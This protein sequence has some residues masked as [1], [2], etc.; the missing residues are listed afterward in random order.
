MMITFFQCCSTILFFIASTSCIT[1]AQRIVNGTVKDEMGETLP[2]VSVLVKGT[3]FFTRTDTTGKFIIEVPKDEKVL[4]FSFLGFQNQEITLGPSNVIEI[5]LTINIDLDEIVITALNIPRS[6]RSLPY[7]VQTV[8]GTTLN[9]MGSS[10]SLEGKIAGLQVLGLSEM[11]LNQSVVSVFRGVGSLT[12]AKT[13]LVVVEGTPVTRDALLNINP[14]NVESITALKGPSAAALYGQRGDAGVLLIKLKKAAPSDGIGIEFNQSMLFDKVTLLPKYQ[15]RYAGGGSAELIRFNWQAGMPEGWKALEGKYYHDY[16]DD[17]SWGPPMDGQEYI[18]WYAW[19][20][21]TKYSFKT[22]TLLPQPNNVRDF[23]GTGLRTNTSLNF[24]KATDAYSTRFSFAFRDEKGLIPTTSNRKFILSST[25]TLNLNKHLILGVNINYSPTTTRGQIYDGT[26]NQ[27]TGSFNSWFHRNLNIRALRELKDLRSPE[28]ILASWNHFN[29]GSYLS[30]P[31]SFYRGNWWFNFYS[32]FDNIEAVDEQKS[33]FGDVNLTYK[34]NNKVKIAGF[35]RQNQ[36]SSDYES[37][38]YNILEQSITSRNLFNSYY[39]YNSLSIE[40]N[41]E[42]LATWADNFGPFNFEANLGGN[43]RQENFKTISNG[44]NQGLKV[45]DLF[46]LNN[47]VVLTPPF[48]YRSKKEVRS[49][50]AR[51]SFAWKEMAYLDWSLRNDWSS[52]LPKDNNAYMYPSVGLSFIFSE[53]F[54]PNNFL[55]FGKLRAG[56]AQVGFD[57]GPYSLNPAYGFLNQWGSNLVITAPN[58]LVEP[59]IKPS[60]SSSYET[61]IDLKMLKNR[62]GISATFYTERRIN[63]ILTVSTSGASGIT[64][65]L[66]NAGRLDR[67]GLEFQLNLM[68]IKRKNFTWDAS[69]NFARMRNKVVELTEGLDAQVTSQFAVSQVNVVGGSWGQLRGGGIKKMDGKPVLTE[70]GLFIQEPDVYFGSVLADFTGGM[71]N[72]LRYKALSLSFNID[73]TVGGKFFSYS[74]LVGEF[75]GIWDQTAAIN[76][77]GKNVRDPVSEGGGVKVSGVDKNG[78]PLDIYVDGFDYYQQFSSANILE[79]YIH[80]RTFIK[81]RELSLACELPVKKWGIDKAVQ[82]AR[83]AFLIKNPW[84]IYAAFQDL[85]LSEQSRTTEAGQF[86]G[87]RSFGFDLRFK[88]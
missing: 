43:I 50:Y 52:A 84:R 87:T 12:G 61:G 37:K 13:P 16:S 29:P 59:G 31:A 19:Y 66:I 10:I 49:V 33:L 11:K 36:N 70:E 60:L 83:I 71:F 68:P 41:Y 55:S 47:S 72:T 74:H 8:S 27:T 21:G 25:S 20:P 15:N 48:N 4:A 77:K 35:L 34:I 85:D 67:N 63:E 51:G 58:V 7:A 69:L 23:Y 5:V 86:P 22:T 76:D 81:C 44:T 40:R 45:P 88:F 56:W 9:P 64:A 75:S 1:H 78:I 57:L 65:Q 2:G 39:V 30:S 62:V 32:Y 79:P 28:G 38:V 6:L 46:K 73:F 3:A 17:T 14:D 26:E 54:R 80:D 53:L 82:S 42:M 24:S 18:P